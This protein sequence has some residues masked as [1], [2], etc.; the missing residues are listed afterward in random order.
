MGNHG[1]FSN[2]NWDILGNLLGEYLV[3]VTIQCPKKGPLPLPWI[4]LLIF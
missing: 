1:M 2:H 4:F 3:S